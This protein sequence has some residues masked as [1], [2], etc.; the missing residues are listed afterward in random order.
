MNRLPLGAANERGSAETIRAS[1]GRGT[2]SLAGRI[3][4]PIE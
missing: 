1:I 3:T 2:P 4:T